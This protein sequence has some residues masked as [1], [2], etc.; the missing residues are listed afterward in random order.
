MPRVSDFRVFYRTEQPVLVIDKIAK[1]DDVPMLIL[2]SY[3]KIEQY[4]KSIN[5]FLVD[6]PYVAFHNP[7]DLNN[8]DVEMGFPTRK[9]LKGKDDVRISSLPSGRV[10][11]CMHLGPRTGLKDIYAEMDIWLEKHSIE[12]VGDIYEHYYNSPFDIAEEHLLTRVVVP[13]K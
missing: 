1:A 6:A 2:E 12:A 8:L 13:I 3:F 10:L 7:K 9:P 4:L 5:E 11:S